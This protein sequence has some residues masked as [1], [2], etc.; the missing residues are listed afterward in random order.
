M[1]F[2]FQVLICML[3]NVEG[4]KNEALKLFYYLA[5]D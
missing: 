1:I 2:S 3:W 4:S 5:V